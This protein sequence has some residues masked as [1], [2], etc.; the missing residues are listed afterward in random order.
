[1]RGYFASCVVFFQAT[2]EI[3]YS[4]IMSFSSILAFSFLNTSCI[5]WKSYQSHK[6]R[7]CAFS[8]R[9][10]VK[11]HYSGII[12]VIIWS[13]HMVTA[14]PLFYSMNV[15]CII[16]KKWLHMMNL[17]G[18]NYLV[19][20]SQSW[21]V[22]LFFIWYKSA[23]WWCGMC[24]NL[25]ENI[26]QCHLCSDRRLNSQILDYHNYLSNTGLEINFFVREPAGD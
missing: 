3:Y 8:W 11:W 23:F 26:F 22:V 15:I 6:A 17:C 9:Y 7:R 21:W 10:M 13:F 16:Y 14:V 24:I 18:L 4:T 19:E 5:I 2:K 1:M 12:M 25:H 20:N